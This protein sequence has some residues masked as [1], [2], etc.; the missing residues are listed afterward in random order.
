ML[1]IY[2]SNRL[3]NLVDHLA[4]M[5]TDPSLAS[6]L[7]Q[8][9]IVVQS[10]GMA[11]WLALELARRL[12]IC[13]N[14]SFPF[15][16]TFIWG[17]FQAVLKDQLPEA[18]P[19]EPMVLAWRL[20]EMLQELEDDERFRPLKA[21]MG[22]ADDSR[23][24]ELA[25]RI[26][27][28]YDQYLVYRPDWIKRWEAGRDEHWQ[29]ELWRRLASGNDLHRVRLQQRFL[30]TLNPITAAALPQRAAFIGIP[31]MPPIHLEIL[32]RVAEHMDIH[33]FLLNPCREY[34]G[35]I[36]AERDIARQG[37]E[38]DPETLYLEVGNSL[39]ASLGKQGRDFIDLVVQTQPGREI[40][41]FAEPPEDSLLH[42]IQ[43][44]I[45]NLHNRGEAD[46]PAV[47]VRADDH[48]LQ[49]H[50]C[51]S[52][53]REVEVLYDQLLALFQADPHLEPAQ[54][55][56]MTPDIEAYGPTI[57]AVFASAEGDRY[58]PFSIAD[59]GIQAES[60]LVDAFFGL[61]D[62]PDGR[63]DANQVLVL[64]ECEAVQRRFGFNPGD[65]ALIYRWVRD[66]GIRWGIDP[67]GRAELDL[68]ATR[69]H[70]WRAGL[71]RLLLG[72]ALPEAELLG[73]ILPY[74]DVEGGEAQVMGRLH[75]FTE[76][77]FSLT[78]VLGGQRTPADWVATLQALLDRFL[79]P[80]ETEEPQVQ[81]IREALE[82]MVGSAGI[83]DF[84]TPLSLPVVKSWLGRYLQQEEGSGRFLTGGVTFCAMLPM[85][86]IPFQVVCLIGMNA[87]SYPRPHRYQSFDLMA[88]RFRRG[89][90][91]RRSDDRYLFLEALLGAR[92]C[93]YLSYVGNDIRD[94]TVIPPSM[95]ISELLDTLAR[96][97]YRE[98]P[99]D[100]LEQV[101]TR[102]P[103]QAFS[104]HYFTKGGRLFSY[105]KELAEAARLAGRGEAEPKA[106]IGQ[107]LP[108][109]E[110]AWCTLDL[111]QLGR[112]LANPTRYLL[113]W[114]L[115]IQL[116]EGEGMLE[117][118]EPFILDPIAQQKLREELLA[119]YLSEVPPEQALPQM[120]A[121]G[122]LPHGRVGEVIFERELDT[123]ERFAARLTKALPK[124][125]L[126]PL[127]IDLE[128]A[129][130][131]LHG[132][133][134]DLGL[135]GIV[136]YRLARV[137]PRD[138]LEL[139][140]RHLILSTLAPVGIGQ[141]SHW[142]G[143][144]KELI[145]NPVDDPRVHLQDLLKL[146][147]QGLHRPL[148][149]F[150][151]S[152]LSYKETADNPKSR[153]PPE[154]AALRTW[155]GSDF[156]RGEREDAYYQLAFRDQYPLDQAFLR[157]TET[158]FGPLFQ[159]LEV[160]K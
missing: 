119:L 141:R 50:A 57:E 80:L 45:L 155:E 63:F 48:S 159:Y 135:Q 103:L 55:V 93:L 18:R 73:E 8:E 42:G 85:R 144:D 90:R 117:T 110:E 1:S 133:L 100:L 28:N 26:A 21:Y 7:A 151:K 152:A 131:R 56:V 13:A 75:S 142:L 12:E 84:R 9:I 33:L 139:W 62:L 11:R 95:L 149:F 96:G 108:D 154:E 158:V 148:H 147:W 38:V 129:G 82:A 112:F 104:R 91:S 37:T 145:L 98:Q 137:R 77:V 109:P 102:H 134:T 4:E 52:P 39:L 78:A 54:V 157:C 6:P 88:R 132:R 121:D 156:A 58:I 124:K 106:L 71:D 17:L 81:S 72:Y 114:R 46:C 76:A 60:Q 107:D 136:S 99:G 32:S 59:R 22:D 89:D 23:C 34:W 69:E 66:T 27:D 31:A 138:Y 65:L 97:F 35:D 20:M 105:S 64:L 153:I 24:Y 143:R 51:H 101:L 94:N 41:A 2:H 61:L 5:I 16:A 118:R 67:A 10:N 15:P 70:T 122:R 111:E 125:P 29:A 49:V 53:M 47:A 92:R 74:A 140:L 115:G 87:D 3:E 127:E 83:A 44:D 120:R 126:E 19:F 30:Q 40:E 79:A 123:V 36:L 160:A 113:R 150:P 128:L 86:S 25:C 14:V 130:I 43:R 146:Y 116:Q 68:P